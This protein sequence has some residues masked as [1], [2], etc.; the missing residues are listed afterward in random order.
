M[1]PPNATWGQI[2]A[3]AQ[4]NQE[5]LKQQEVIKSLQNVLQT[6]VSVCTSLGNPYISQMAQLVDTMLQVGEGVRAE[7]PLCVV[8]W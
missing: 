4:A 6:N 2:L 3:Q 1:A 7:G 8:C 5:V